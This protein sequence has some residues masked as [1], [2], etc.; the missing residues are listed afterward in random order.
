[1]D[2]TESSKSKQERIVKP[3]K[4]DDGEVLGAPRST[5]IQE[6]TGR[7]MPATFYANKK[8]GMT[9]ALALQYFKN[10]I[11][12][13]YPDMTPENPIAVICDGHGSHLSCQL[14]TFCREVGII[15]LLRPPHTT[16]ISQG[17]DVVNFGKFKP[18]FRTAKAH[19]LLEKLNTGSKTLFLDMGDLMPC[20]AAAWEAA[21]SKK[22]NTK[23]W[24]AIGVNPFTRCVYWELRRK[25]EAAQAR[26]KKVEGV[27]LEDEDVKHA[28]LLK[29]ELVG[30]L[31][32]M[33][34][35]PASSAR[36]E[37][38]EGALQE[39]LGQPTPAATAEEEAAAATG[40]AAAEPAAVTTTAIAATSSVAN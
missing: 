10:N 4:E 1:M 40:A 21:F 14:L 31:R 29:E 33:G 18:L 24:A 17:E 26:V 28:K 25:E 2:C 37:V 30:V 32:G 7:G 27:N 39:L 9:H 6:D 34:E 20:T 23:A 38:L 11:A 35:T 15:I 8:G 16:N 13:M 5:V 12:T 19:R 22:E 3:E 36:K